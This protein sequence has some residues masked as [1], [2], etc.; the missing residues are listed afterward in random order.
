MSSLNPQPNK[1]VPTRY[2]WYLSVVWIYE[3]QKDH[4]GFVSL[5]NIRDNSLG[6]NADPTKIRNCTFEEIDAINYFTQ[7]RL[8]DAGSNRKEERVS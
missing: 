6:I 7:R 4:R 8:Y 1:D 5:I 2:V 3:G